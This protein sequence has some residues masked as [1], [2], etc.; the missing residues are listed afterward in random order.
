[1][2]LS[3]NLSWLELIIDFTKIINKNKIYEQEDL[4]FAVNKN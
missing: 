4:K 3:K 1:M 2:V